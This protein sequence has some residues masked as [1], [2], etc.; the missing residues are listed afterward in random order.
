MK[1]MKFEPNKE[2]IRKHQVPEWF[3]DAK[4]GIFIHWGLYSVPAFAVKGLNLLES[5]KRGAEEH[6]KNNP[7]AEWYLNS[8]R[9]IG[10]PTQKYH[11]ETYGENFSYDDFV[12]MFNEAIKKWNPDEMATAWITLANVL[13][14]R[15][16]GRWR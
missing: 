6:F 7:F 2:S 9:I 3:H 16:S 1:K 12:P 8:L 10:S 13:R 4:L 14:K 5:E 15:G 11:R